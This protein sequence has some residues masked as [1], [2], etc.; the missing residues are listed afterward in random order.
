MRPISTPGFLISL[1]ALAAATACGSSGS[2]PGATRAP[3]KSGDVWIIANPD[4]RA[5]AP[6]AILAF[7]HGLHSFVLDGNDAYL[8]M[9]RV[10]ARRG[11]NGARVIAVPGAGEVQLVAVGDSLE[12]RFPSGET[13]PLI[14]RRSQDK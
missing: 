8:G 14:R 13:V 10:Q 1:L 6:G 4:E 9:T 5:S 12:L 7:V 11:E 3:S 2:S